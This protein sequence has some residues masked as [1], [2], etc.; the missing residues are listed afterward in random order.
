M[1]LL[2]LPQHTQPILKKNSTST[3][4]S[5]FCTRWPPLTPTCPQA[6][7]GRPNL[8]CL[9][10]RSF[11]A[12]ARLCLTRVIKN[13]RQT[14]L[15][16]TIRKSRSLRPW[17][18]LSLAFLQELQDQAAGRASRSPSGI[19][20]WEAFAAERQL[21]INPVDVVMNEA[22]APDWNALS[23]TISSDSPAP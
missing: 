4:F 10:A 1:K 20:S 21:S 8:Q 19:A 11:P 23:T 17:T 15:P 18:L 3:S 12:K 6:A 16:P 22:P 13:R 7:G 2:P 14:V 9:L 5:A